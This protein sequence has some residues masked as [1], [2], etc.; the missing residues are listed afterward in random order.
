MS[1]GEDIQRMSLNGEDGS[2]PDPV[3]QAAKDGKVPTLGEVKRS[4]KVSKVFFSGS[5]MYSS[6]LFIG[7]REETYTCYDSNGPSP[8]S[9]FGSLLVLSAELMNFL[10]RRYATFKLFYN[11]NAPADYEPPHFRAG[12]SD[13]DKWFFSTH[14][15]D[16][17]PERVSVGNLET[18]LHG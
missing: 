18:G 16:E 3:A 12:D 8:K 15:R 9:V 5:S 1:L 13:K 2:R 6:S 7:A 10:E 11:D 14:G 17:V 4:V